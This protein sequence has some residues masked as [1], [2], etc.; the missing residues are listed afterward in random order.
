M[1]PSLFFM[2]GIFLLVFSLVFV[3]CLPSAHADSTV[4]LTVK[5]ANDTIPT[6]VL[7]VN[8]NAKYT[9]SQSY[10]W[11]KDQTSRYNLQAYSIDNGPHVDIPRVAR[12][13]FTLDVPTDSNHEI[14][15]ITTIQY[16][17]ETI[18]T[19]QVSFMP[20]S[21]TNDNWFDINSDELVSVPYVIQSDAKD[22]REQL[23]GWSYDGE[24]YSQIKR[25]EFGFYNTLPI[26]MSGSHSINFIYATQYYL[27][28][29]SEYGHITG[30][31]WYDSNTN[32]TI[33]SSSGDD[34][35][36]RHVFSG[37][38]GPVLDS[39]KQTTN[40]LME[41]PEIVV[42]NWTID[43]T[44]VIL[45]GVIVI[46][47]SGIILYLKRRTSPH[48]QVLSKKPESSQNII[49]L[50]STIDVQSEPS[51]NTITDNVYSKEIDAYV[52]GKS[53]ERLE[54]FETSGV[55]SKE[56]HDKLKTKVTDGTSD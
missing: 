45:M 20:L 44:P 56:R 51:V 54:M 39:H 2:F 10:S 13:N 36:V 1:K 5:Y 31:G 41:G 3:N 11:V 47:A 35:P 15:F 55:L 4:T 14:V 40:V 52:I 48:K 49:R 24:D 37:W 17:I 32:A 25:S 29:V 28:L 46:A 7:S 18:G 26:R 43:Y 42:A 19:S 27:N 30:S 21:P 50:E 9:L 16:P 53:I 23:K 6:T 22:T 38:N 33:S 12:G 34:F 8:N